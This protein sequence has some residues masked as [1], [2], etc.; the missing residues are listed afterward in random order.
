MPVVPMGFIA[1]AVENEE[2]RPGGAKK[3]NQH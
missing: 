2:R 1:A 3:K